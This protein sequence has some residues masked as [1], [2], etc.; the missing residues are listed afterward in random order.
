MFMRDNSI[1]LDGSEQDA[2][3]SVWDIMWEGSYVYW[4]I[5]SILACLTINTICKMR[6][7]DRLGLGYIGR[8]S[9]MFYVSHWVILYIIHICIAILTNMG[10][11]VPIKSFV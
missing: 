1:R 2:S 8:N 9:M 3:G 10:F 11:D 4:L 5:G 6:I 7:F